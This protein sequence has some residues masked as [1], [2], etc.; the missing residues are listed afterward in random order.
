[1]KNPDC[2]E[3]LKRI[4]PLIDMNKIYQIIDETDYISD[5]RKEFYKR[6]INE[7]YTKILKAAYDKLCK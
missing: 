5:I 4:V 3:A 6:I 2:N 1:L 7:R